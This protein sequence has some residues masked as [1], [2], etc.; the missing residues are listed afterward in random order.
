MERLLEYNRKDLRSWAGEELAAQFFDNR[1]KY[2][3]P[4]NNLDYWI[5]KSTPEKL[6]DYMDNYKSK[7]QQRKE[8][9]MEGAEKVYDDGRWVVILCKTYEAMAYYGKGTKWC[10]AGNYPGHEGRGAEYFNSYKKSRYLDY[11][12]FIDRQGEQGNDK[13]CVCP[14]QEDSSKCD[15]WNAPDV[16]VDCIEGAPVVK[17]LPAVSSINIDD[18]GVLVKVKNARS[19]YKGSLSIPETVKS[20]GRKALCGVSLGVVFI[21]STVESIG[22]GAFAECQY[23]KSLSIPSSVKQT[24]TAIALGCDSLEKVMIKENSI[25]ALTKNMFAFCDSLT[26]VVVK[27]TIESI[28][29]SWIQGSDNVTIYLDENKNAKLLEWAKQYHAE[30][31]SLNSGESLVKR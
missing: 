6:K 2:P 9:T 26:D 27:S 17:G 30:V 13:W 18:N 29:N 1:S 16:T 10:I 12:V 8:V 25:S 7:N 14:Y 20:I 19:Y 15:I 28:D 4:Y 3:S 23:L 24:G 5:S 21:P 22:S 11:Y 31:V